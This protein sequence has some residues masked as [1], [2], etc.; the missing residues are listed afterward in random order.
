MSGLHA[1]QNKVGEGGR[2]QMMIH[3]VEKHNWEKKKMAAWIREY[4]KQYWKGK[5]EVTLKIDHIF[6][7]WISPVLHQCVLHVLLFSGTKKKKKNLYRRHWGN[8]HQLI[9][10]SE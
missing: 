5:D 7:D 4:K 8:L 3:D 10:F 1:A 9:S 6:P 2:K